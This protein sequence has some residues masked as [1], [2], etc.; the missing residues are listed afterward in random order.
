MQLTDLHAIL[1]ACPINFLRRRV[2]YALHH[3]V[4]HAQ[5]AYLRISVDYEEG[6]LEADQ[7]LFA[8]C[9]R[10][11]QTTRVGTAFVSAM[12]VSGSLRGT[13]SK[14]LKENPSVEKGTGVAMH[15][16][17]AQTEQLLAIDL[18]RRSVSPITAPELVAPSCT[19]TADRRVHA[20]II[21]AMHM[22]TRIIAAMQR[23]RD[24]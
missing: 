19:V 1:Q 4:H 5:D 16:F 9:A 14:Y 6:K 7:K 13:L 18:E 20:R 15:Q 10:P 11:H 17:L 2:V 3:A 24:E 8:R 12:Y 23:S 22:R 21:A